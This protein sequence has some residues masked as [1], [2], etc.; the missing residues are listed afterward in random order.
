[1]TIQIQILTNIKRLNNSINGNPKYRLYFNNEVLTT[2]TDSMVA[3]KID[4]SLI[5]KKLAIKYHLTP[6]KQQ[7]ILDNFKVI[8]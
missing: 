3:Y 8:D 2:P 1:M 5:G 4:N 6:K 7:A